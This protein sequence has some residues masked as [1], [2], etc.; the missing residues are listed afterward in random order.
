M[1]VLQENRFFSNKNFDKNDT[2]CP[3]SRAYDYSYIKQ[4]QPQLF[5]ASMCKSKINSVVSFFENWDQSRM[6]SPFYFGVF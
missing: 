3:E 5:D 4:Q 6:V 1:A 2:G